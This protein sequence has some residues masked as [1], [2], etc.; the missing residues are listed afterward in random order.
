[1]PRHLRRHVPLPIL[2]LFTVDLLLGAAHALDP[3]A[4]DWLGSTRGGRH[5]CTGTESTTCPEP[6][7]NLRSEVSLATWYSSLHLALIG[8][9]LVGFGA[10]RRNAGLHGFWTA[11]LIGAFFLGLSADEAL[12]IHEKLAASFQDESSDR[13]GTTFA[14]TGPWM[15]VAGPLFVVVLGA[16]AVG[17]RRLLAGAPRASWLYAA[18]ALIFL[19][20]FA[21]LE[22]LSNFVVA[23]EPLVAALEEVGEMIGATV[24]LWATLELLRAHGRETVGRIMRGQAPSG[25]G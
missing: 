6:F 25:T 1:M 13:A 22:F 2:A 18:G 17:A 12:A 24:L 4:P 23:R 11:L 8:L 5:Q 15:L 19:G 14:R 10:L 9:V 3:P 16:G 20:S 7:W 21:G